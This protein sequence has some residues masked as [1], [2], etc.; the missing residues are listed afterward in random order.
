M[1]AIGFVVAK[2]SGRSCRVA[3]DPASRNTQLRATI[4]LY[5]LV[6]DSVVIIVVV[7]ST[8][9]AKEC[10]ELVWRVWRGKIASRWILGGT[11]HSS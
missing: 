10:S 7:Q 9:R 11:I 6:L 5:I 4:S 3:P 2:R 1:T 8:Q